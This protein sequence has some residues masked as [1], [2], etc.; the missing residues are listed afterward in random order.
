MFTVTFFLGSDMHPKLR[1]CRPP[2]GGSGGQAWVLR[3]VM[4]GSTAEATP[5]YNILRDGGVEGANDLFLSAACKQ[6]PSLSWFTDATTTWCCFLTTPAS[7]Q[8]I[9]TCCLHVPL[10]DPEEGGASGV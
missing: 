6:R 9:S 8:C 1:L 4:D 2:N 10:T 7:P 5:L 3:C